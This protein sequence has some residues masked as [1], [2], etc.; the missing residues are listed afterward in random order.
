MNTLYTIPKHVIW[1]FRYYKLLLEIFKLP[2]NTSETDFSKFLKVSIKSRNLNIPRKQ[3]HV[4]NLQITCP[5]PH[6]ICSHLKSPNSPRT[7]ILELLRSH[8]T[9]IAHKVA[10]PKTFQK[11]TLNRNL[12][13][14]SPKTT[15]NMPMSH[16]RPPNERQG[17]TLDPLPPPPCE[18]AQFDLQAYSMLSNCNRN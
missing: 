15:Y 4:R 12:Q 7:A 16:H 13:R 18:G 10:K 11:F 3:S 6:T 8:Y 5:K 9:K 2:E 14:I 1:R 17:G